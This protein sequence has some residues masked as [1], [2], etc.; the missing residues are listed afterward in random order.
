LAK[1][2]EFTKGLKKPDEIKEAAGEE[3]EDIPNL[4]GQNFE[5]ADKPA[6]K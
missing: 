2:R 4:V 1:L 6:D 5:K 3:E